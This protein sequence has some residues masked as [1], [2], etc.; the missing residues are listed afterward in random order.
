MN[1]H[2]SS[3]NWAA[4][5]VL[6]AGAFMVVLDFFIVNVALPSIATDLHAG[7]SSLEWVV[8]GYGLT[9]AAFLITAGRLG[10]A[11][12]RRRMYAVGLTLFTLSSAACGLAPSPTTLVAARIAQGLAGGVLM[13][14]VLAIVG[15]TYRGPDYV[16]ALSIY[17]VVL[18][19]AAVGGQVIGGVLVET[20]LL[21]LGWR[22]CFLINVPIGIAALILG[23]RLVP[24]SRSDQ[25]KRIDYAGAALLAAGLTSVLLPLIEGR[26][27]GWPTWTWISLGVAPLIVGAFLR[28]QQRLGRNGGD[29]LL[30]LRL[31][32]ERAFSAGLATQLFLAG[33]QASFFVFFA[34]YLQMGRGLGALQAGLVFTI[35]ALAYVV[36][37]G[38]AP[39]LTARFGRAVVVAGGVALTLGLAAL[40]LAVEGIGTTGSLLALVPGLL[41]VGAGIG[42]CFT[43][44]TSMVLKH[45]DPARAGSAAGAM[46]T[47]QQVGYSLGVAITG[48]VY[49]GAG[50]D[51]GHAFQLSLLQLAAVAAAIVVVARLLPGVSGANTGINLTPSQQIADT[52]A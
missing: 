10:D 46:S 20:D 3:T 27:H 15:V 8:A 5:P 35:L 42:L 36:T 23:P 33:A 16:R 49:F 1:S 48:V 2:R 24:E 52:V 51:I 17:G 32:E 28:R 18:G 22:S 19:L 41:L 43:P 39:G 31:F 47:T 9:F 6:L 29:P 13:P 4:L 7:D 50:P 45:V 26:Q 11:I 40:A 12:G 14:Q 30:D 25:S 44:L 37:S 38:P 34:L 21:G